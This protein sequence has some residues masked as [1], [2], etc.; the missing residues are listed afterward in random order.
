MCCNRECVWYM[1]RIIYRGAIWKEYSIIIGIK[2]SPTVTTGN[3]PDNKVHVASMGPTWVL[4]APD[5]PHVGPMK[6]AIRESNTMLEKCVGTSL[7]W[8]PFSSDEHV[9]P[10]YVGLLTTYCTF[11]FKSN[12]RSQSVFNILQNNAAFKALSFKQTRYHLSAKS[13]GPNQYPLTHLHAVNQL[14]NSFPINL[15][16][17]TTDTHI[18][19]MWLI[20]LHPAFWGKWGILWI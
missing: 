12:M 7:Y 1:T 10:S 2:I 4:S 15:I 14:I 19:S 8:R 9:L 18:I 13:I 3:N 16:E 6:L 11:L 17:L 20:G 5:G